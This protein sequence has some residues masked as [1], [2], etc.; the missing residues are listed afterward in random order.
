MGRILLVSRLV[1]RDVRRRPVG[2]LILLLGVAVVTTALS[3]GLILSG[4]TD[5]LYQQT[6]EQTRGPDVVAV[7]P[8][9]TADS[10][11]A[12]TDL[13]HG[14]GVVRYGGPYPVVETTATAHD[15]TVNVMAIGRETAPAAVDQPLV[16]AG[17]WVRA[18][19]VV[20]ERGFANAV[21][22]HTGDSI[23]VAGKDFLVAGLAVTAA[24]PVYPGGLQSGD[25]GP[26]EHSAGRVWL[27]EDDVRSLLVPQTSYLANIALADPAATTEFTRSYR[28]AEVPVHFFKWQFIADADALVIRTTEPSLVVGS[29]LLAVLAVCCVAGLVAGRTA[30]QVRRVGLLKAVGAGP[31]LVAAVVLAEYVVF[32][33][34]ADVLGLAAGW[35]LSR[36][37]SD[38]SSG[39]VDSAPP[40]G[41]GTVVTVTI[42]AVAMA[43][44]ATLG[45]TLRAARTSTVDAL[46]AAPQ[47]PPEHRAARMPKSFGLPT[48]FL[49]GLRLIARRPGHAMRSAAGVATTS[50]TLVALV[51]LDAQP[52]HGYDLGPTVLTNL[53]EQVGSRV[54][55][56]ITVAMIGLAAVNIVV[57]TWSTAQDARH[58]LAVARTL[59]ATPAQVTGGLCVAQLLPA[60][61]GALLGIPVG[62]ALFGL[63]SA[64][65]AVWP[66][67]VW[68]FVAALGTL[69]GVAACT[70]IPARLEARRPVADVLV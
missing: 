28:S 45:P 27:T 4:S 22:V 65:N 54:L 58:S 15:Q 10:L 70:A 46:A 35:F 51:C 1:L 61:P 7:S 18:G 38:P 37:L 5:A 49:L 40:L 26:T 16:T 17:S 11:A 57:T 8:D 69:A 60:L 34:A 53:R 20:V 29:W 2:A 30:A 3:V 63:F 66:A 44:V 52:S 59:G 12:M 67:P 64:D 32:A 19:G 24:T 21:G 55:L 62:L 39:M 23:S 43:V 56:I 9:A 14:P 36:T 25:G 41:V 68:L 6:R 42:L 31:G 47:R 50:T 33:L 13:R 48:S